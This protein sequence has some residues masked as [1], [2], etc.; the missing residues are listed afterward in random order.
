MHIPGGTDE[1]YEMYLTVASVEIRIT[2]LQQINEE[3]YRFSQTVRLVHQQ[4]MYGAQRLA[5]WIGSRKRFEQNVGE[6]NSHPPMEILT[7]N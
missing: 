7:I 6:T 4:K 2:Y 5:G 3:S 1:T